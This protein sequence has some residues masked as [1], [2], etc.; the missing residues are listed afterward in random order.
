MYTNLQDE[1]IWHYDKRGCFYVKFAY[2]LANY[3]PP[4]LCLSSN[5]STPSIEQIMGITYSTENQTLYFLTC[6]NVIPTNFNL[7]KRKVDISPIFPLYNLEAETLPI[8]YLH[9][10]W[11]KECGLLLIC[12][13]ELIL[14]YIPLLQIGL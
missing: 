11:L 7:W 2:Q 3:T 5:K 4:V 6:K 12:L 9:V 8:V 10:R 13:Q 1:I 14:T